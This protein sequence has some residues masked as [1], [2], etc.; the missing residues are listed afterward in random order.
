MSHLCVTFLCKLSLAVP[1]DN[2]T[3]SDQLDGALIFLSCQ[4]I[5]NHARITISTLD[6]NTLLIIKKYYSLR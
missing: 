3:H 6:L 4:T 2:A 5:F 1:N